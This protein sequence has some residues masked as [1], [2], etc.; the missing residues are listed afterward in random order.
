MHLCRI[1]ITNT[2]Y[3]RVKNKCIEACARASACARGHLL[4]IGAAICSEGF[5]NYV[6]QILAA[7]QLQNFLT[8]YGTLKKQLTK[9]LNKLLPHNVCSEG[10]LM[11]TV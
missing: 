3:D 10:V 2:I 8:A 7:W 6:L 11:Q 5:A 4:H 1:A 9:P